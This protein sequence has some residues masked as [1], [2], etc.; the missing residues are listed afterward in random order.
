MQ[1]RA[2]VFFCFFRLKNV[3]CASLIAL[4]WPN[5]VK[6]MVLHLILVCLIELHPKNKRNNPPEDD[7]YVAAAALELVK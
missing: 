5:Q 4:A 6:T 3:S 7:F 2:S 1:Q